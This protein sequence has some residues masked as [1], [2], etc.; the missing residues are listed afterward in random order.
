MIK[1]KGLAF[2]GLILKSKLIYVL[3]QSETDIEDRTEENEVTGAGAETAVSGSDARGFAWLQMDSSG[4]IK[5]H[6]KWNDLSSDL[7]SIQIDNG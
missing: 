4:L 2:L 5:Y 1:N 3:T 6:L 7:V